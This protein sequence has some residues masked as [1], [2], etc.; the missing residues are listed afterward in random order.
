[1]DTAAGYNQSVFTLGYVSVREAVR[2]RVQR[3]NP[4]RRIEREFLFE[5][6]MSYVAMGTRGMNSDLCELQMR[7][8]RVR[9]R[10]YHTSPL[11]H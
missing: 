6:N 2:D 8:E 11:N 7:E 1:M 4:L 5:G 3:S 9:L 10:G